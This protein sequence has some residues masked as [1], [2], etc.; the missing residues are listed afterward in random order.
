MVGMAASPT[1]KPSRCRYTPLL[2]FPS[3]KTRPPPN[4]K[5]R[6]SL[7][8]SHGRGVVRCSSSR[9]PSPGSGDND[10]K[11]V[12]DAFFLG[13]AFAEALNERI[14]STVGEIFSV[15][16]QWQAEQQKQVL[17]FQEEV[18]ERAKK[19]KEKAALEVVAEQGA[20]KSLKAPSDTATPDVSPPSPDPKTEDSFQD[21][22]KD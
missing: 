4:L 3:S 1:V 2:P 20:M 17:D 13:K 22:L 9:T 21:T 11:G 15:I 19:A 8:R 5:P 14:G 6:T 10:N 18:I 12:L 16:G 7:R